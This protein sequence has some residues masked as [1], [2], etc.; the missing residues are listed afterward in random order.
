MRPCVFSGQR[1]FGSDAIL[2]RPLVL[3]ALLGVLLLAC[4]TVARPVEAASARQCAGGWLRQHRRPMERPISG[5]FDSLDALYDPEFGELCFVIH[6]QPE[7]FIVVAGDDEVTPVIAFSSTGFVDTSADNPLRIL[8]KNDLKGRFA[9]VRQKAPG[10]FRRYSP[11]HRWQRYMDIEAEA[12]LGGDAPESSAATTSISD[13]RVDPLTIMEWGQ[14]EAAGGWCYNYYTPSHYPC[15]CV[16]TAMAQVMLYHRWP[17]EGIGGGYLG[18]DG[19]GGPYDWDQMPYV[20]DDGLT[21]AQRQMIG[22]LCRD[23]G[24]AVNMSYSP[25]V[26]LAGLGNADKALVN[27]FMYANSIYTANVAPAGNDYL[28]VMINSNLDAALPVLLAVYRPEGGHAI[29]ADGYGYHDELM[30]HHL[31]MGWDGLDNAWYQLPDIDTSLRDYDTIEKCVYNIYPEGTGQIISGRVLDSAGNPCEGVIVTARLGGEAVAQKVTNQRGIYALTRLASNTQYQLHAQ[32]EGCSFTNQVVTTGRSIDGGAVSGNRWPVNFVE[33]AAFGPPIALDAV[34][35]ANSWQLTTFP[36]SAID[37]DPYDPNNPSDPNFYA[38]IITSLPK[39]CELSEP[40]IGPIDTVPYALVSDVNHLVACRPCPYYCGQDSFTFKV[41]DGGTFPTGGESNI[42]TVYIN[43]NNMVQTGFASEPNDYGPHEY[44][45]LMMDTA[46]FYDVRSQVIYRA[47][48]IQPS[49]SFT[50]LSLNVSTAP[51]EPLNNW[52]IRMQH[53]DRPVYDDVNDLHSQFMT[54]GWT[55]VYQGPMPSQTGW[56]ELP[57]DVPFRYNGQQHLLIDF[58]YNNSTCTAPSGAYWNCTVPADRALTLASE[59]GTHGDPL[60]WN[61]WSLGGEHYL[62]GEVPSIQLTGTIIHP[63][64][65]DF[66]STCRV[67]LPDL[68]VFAQAWQSSSGDA[69]Y[70]VQCDLTEVKGVIDLQDMILLS[71]QWLATYP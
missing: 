8:L 11:R 28:W 7:G 36:L 29:I 62:S 52:T 18:G 49:Q 60:S 69:H 53:T 2:S 16:A 51:G 55:T 3:C 40:N 14:E 17:E 44:G 71:E 10:P 56:V 4:E 59:T 25:G 68:M 21:T 22:R 9:A 61:F 20:P 38:Y 48:D 67:A 66:D 13:V 34:V 27:T 70:D 23:A 45:T 32:A 57:F 42:A 31:N 63:I 30:Y 24:L 12:Q 64:P 46:S 50:G 15:G 33:S 26:S 65:G 19:A 37:E 6:L 58:C 41:H 39:Y 47:G 35:D 54:E 1:G 5:R 43:V